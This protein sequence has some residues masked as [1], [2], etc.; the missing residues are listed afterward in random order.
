MSRSEEFLSLYNK[1]VEHLSQIAGESQ[2]KSFYHLIEKAAIKDLAIRN[3]KKRLKVYGKLRD[4]IVHS[5]DS[6]QEEIE[7]PSVAVLEKFKQVAEYIISPPK[8]I[9]TFKCSLR[10]FNPENKLPDV[11]KFMKENDY[12]QVIVKADD[13]ISLIT[14]EGVARWLTFEIN[15][16]IISITETKLSDIIPHE[17]PDGLVIM[18]QNKTVDHAKEVFEKSLES[19]KARLYCILITHDGEMFGDLMGIVTPWDII[20]QSF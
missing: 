10:V 9:P 15:E 20:E 1:V 16:D 13:R 19:Q 11:L 2:R 4:A 6:P 5:K 7:E 3:H 12:S 14:A 8:L 18:D 17:I